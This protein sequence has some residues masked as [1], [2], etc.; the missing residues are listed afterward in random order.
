MLCLLLAFVAGCAR[1]GSVQV[2]GVT[3]L[4]VNKAGESTPVNVRIYQLKRGDRFT[5]ASFDSLW[6]DDRTTLGEDLH[7]EPLTITVYPGSADEEPRVHD[8]GELGQGVEAIGVMALYRQAGPEDQRTALVPVD[9]LDDTVLV[10]SQYS[11]RLD[12]TR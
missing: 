7:G 9:Q 2:R 12:A 5:A 8:L 6:T 4:H 10:F 1:T 11:V 3:P